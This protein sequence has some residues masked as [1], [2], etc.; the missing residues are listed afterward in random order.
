MIASTFCEVRLIGQMFVIYVFA[1]YAIFLV[2]L[3]YVFICGNNRFHRSG[4]IGSCYRFIFDT[5]PQWCGNLALRFCPERCNGSGPGGCCGPKGPCRY[6][7][8]LFYAVLYAFLIVV[9]VRRV[10][11]YLR[12]I[13]PDNFD[14]H[15]RLTFLVLPWPWLIVLLLRFYDPGIVNRH[16]V[17]SYMKEYP[18]DNVL[19]HPHVCPT[20][21]IPVPAR[22]RYCRYTN[23]RVA[24]L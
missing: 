7:I 5:I 10:T 23:R 4:F 2:F 13:Y 15:A 12:H 11:P 16:N 8:I 14:L 20:L 1:G 24:F 19:Y 18:P 17:N 3:I 9:Y 6:F 21:R 22:S